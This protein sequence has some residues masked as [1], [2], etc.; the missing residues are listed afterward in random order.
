MQ[1][2]LSSIAIAMRCT[3]ACALLINFVQNAVFIVILCTCADGCIINGHIGRVVLSY[4]HSSRTTNQSNTMRLGPAVVDAPIHA[5]VLVGL[6]F[7]LTAASFS[8]EACHFQR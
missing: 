7:R 5:S 1:K 8:V 6:C 3:A 4:Q 2:D